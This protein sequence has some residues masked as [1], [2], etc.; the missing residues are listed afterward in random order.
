MVDGPFI[1]D[2]D[3]NI[4][5]ELFIGDPS[6]GAGVSGQAAFI[7]LTIQRDSDSRYWTGI[8]WVAPRTTVSVTEFDAVNEPGRYTYLLSGIANSVAT[9]YFVRALIDN[10]PMFDAVP[11]SEVH[12]SRITDVK[13]YESEPA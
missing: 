7:T 3:E 2:V 6:T 5:I 4:P 13:V 10:P 1:W 9:R 8:S 12:V 11:S